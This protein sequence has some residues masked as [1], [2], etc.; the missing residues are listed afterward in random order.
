MEHR[1]ILENTKARINRNYD[2]RKDEMKVRGI[3]KVVLEN[4]GL[5]CEDTFLD[6]MAVQA[7]VVRMDIM[8]NSYEKVRDFKKA[9]AVKEKKEVSLF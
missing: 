3:R 1:G 8:G 4:V 9:K 2:W 5:D 6:F 7:A